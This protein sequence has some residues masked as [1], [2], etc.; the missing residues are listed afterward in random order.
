MNTSF[1]KA[2]NFCCMNTK[3]TSKFDFIRDSYMLRCL[4][5]NT[6]FYIVLFLHIYWKYFRSNISI[7]YTYPFYLLLFSICQV[8]KKP[9]L[10]KIIH[11][12]VTKMKSQC[13]GMI[14]QKYLINHK[15]KFKSEPKPNLHSQMK[16]KSTYTAIKSK[17]QIKL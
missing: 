11:S 12:N 5:T 17:E 10:I 2:T 8:V 6:V 3:Q 4:Q 14:H 9:Q 13:V 7:W 1:G 15:Q 16:F